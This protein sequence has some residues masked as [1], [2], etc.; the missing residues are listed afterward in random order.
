MRMKISE[1]IEHILS[2]AEEHSRILKMKRCE[3]IE[4]FLTMAQELLR[5][6]GKKVYFEDLIY[7][8]CDIS[9]YITIEDYSVLAYFEELTVNCLM[10]WTM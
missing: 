5:F 10:I 3:E 2:Q 9:T 7:V 8:Q 4:Q 1:D 6:Q